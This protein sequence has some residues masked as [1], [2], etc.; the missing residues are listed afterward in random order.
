VNGD[1][2]DTLLA[3]IILAVMVAALVYLGLTV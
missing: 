3:V 1:R 2:L